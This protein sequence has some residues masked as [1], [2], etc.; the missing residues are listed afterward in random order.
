MD[1]ARVNGRRL[2]VRRPLLRQH[3]EI[4]SFR[5]R[6]ENTQISFLIADGDYLQFFGIVERQYSMFVRVAQSEHALFDFVAPPTLD[7]A[8]YD[9][10]EHVP[11]L[12][13]HIHQNTSFGRSEG[14]QIRARARVTR[15]VSNFYDPFQIRNGDD[16][17]II[18]PF[19][20][21]R[22]EWRRALAYALPHPRGAFR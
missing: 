3:D 19:D 12:Q 20:T 5:I 6:V 4:I 15:N 8:A 1:F 10:R 7:D 11:V 17:R 22:H 21:H 18:R 14:N 9:G 13:E 2:F 16:V